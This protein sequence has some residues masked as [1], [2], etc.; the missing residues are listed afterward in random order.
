MVHPL[1]SQV[2]RSA[3]VSR[4][5]DRLSRK[6]GRTIR[7]SDGASRVVKRANQYSVV[8]PVAPAQTKAVGIH[9]DGT[10]FSYF[11]QVKVGSKDKPL[12]MLVDTGAGTTW[13]PSSTCVSSTC[14]L[15]D[16]LGPGDST[17]LSITTT[18]FDIAYGSG[19]VSGR[20][21][22]DSFAVAGI[23]MSYQ[24][25]LAEQTSDAFAHFPFDGILGLSMAKGKNQNFL[26]AIKD[27]KQ[28]SSNLFCI[29]LN[30]NA[31]G[32]NTGELSFGATNPAKFTGNIVYSPVSPKAL[33]DWA[34]TM[35][36]VSYDGKKVDSINISK[37][38]LGYIDTGTSYV[39]GPPADVYALHMLIPGATSTDNQTYT[40]PCDSTKPLAFTFAGVSYTVSPKDWI[41]APTSNGICTSNIYGREVVPNGDW[42]LGDL[43]IKNVYAVF[44][45]D[46][47]SVGMYPILPKCLVAFN[48]APLGFANR[49]ALP[50]AA[51]TPKPAGSTPTP[52][53]S[54]LESTSSSTGITPVPTQPSSSK[55]AQGLSGHET[56]GTAGTPVAQTAGSSP[57]PT[58]SSPAEQ[59]DGPKYVS[60]IC[61][62]AAIVIAA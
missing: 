18:K 48:K 57:S 37:A 10:D 41:S 52:T 28:L 38:K 30:R 60:I 15:H 19:T 27:T 20:L 59:L 42:L 5:A 36:A 17:T 26:S 58:P 9:Q 39:F 43:F 2:P 46:K 56:S 6:Y 32:P 61:I 8:A 51:E 29:Y 45:A 40:V 50:A 25:G 62:V 33:G 47:Q 1:Q 4:Q 49:A 12:Y 14:S 21:A 34:I 3:L 7:Y 11:V 23:K 13:V 35:E 53:P 31:D 24:F 44:D 54:K 22:T 16:T 55:P